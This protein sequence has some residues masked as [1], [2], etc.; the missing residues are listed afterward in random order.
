MTNKLGKIPHPEN[1]HIP[2]KG[3]FESVICSFPQFGYP[4]EPSRHPAVEVC[5]AYPGTG[6][7][8]C[9]YLASS[10][11]QRGRVTWGVTEIFWSRKGYSCII[12]TLQKSG[13]HS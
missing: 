11:Q 10:T 5:Y 12:V 13:E 1:Q 2:F 9:R 4:S 3:T 7:L 8:W 6:S